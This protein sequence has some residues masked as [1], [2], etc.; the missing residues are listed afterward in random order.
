M[1]FSSSRVLQFPCFLRN[2]LI[3]MF[4]AQV[5]LICKADIQVY[6]ENQI[7]MVVVLN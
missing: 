5:M 6:C 2:M 3:I 1:I 4:Y 7:F